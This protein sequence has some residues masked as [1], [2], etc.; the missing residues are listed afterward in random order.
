MIQAIP[1]DPVA[2]AGPFRLPCPSA[3]SMNRATT[4]RPPS[5]QKAERILPVRFRSAFNTGQP[6]P[7]RTESLLASRTLR[8]GRPDCQSA[9]CAL[10]APGGPDAASPGPSRLVR[11]KMELRGGAT[12]PALRPVG[13]RDLDAGG[14]LRPGLRTFFRRRMNFLQ[15]LWMIDG[16]LSL[17]FF[18]PALL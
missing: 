13:P 7:Y 15:E 16:D 12:E 8:S 17:L 11:G 14:P 4:R 6:I 2:L 1:V 5:L 18:V 10:P 9:C 3:Q